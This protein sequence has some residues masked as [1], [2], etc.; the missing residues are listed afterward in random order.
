MSRAN[1]IERILKKIA[2][3][4]RTT[5]ENVRRELELLIDNG[6]KTPDPVIH[7]RWLL[8]GKGEKPTVQEL[9]LFSADAVKNM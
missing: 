1:N 4:H 6:W 9:I 2:K 5:P 7:A 8:I 3:K